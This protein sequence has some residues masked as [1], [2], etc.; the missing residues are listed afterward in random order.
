[1]KIHKKSYMRRQFCV[2]NAFF[3]KRKWAF[4]NNFFFSAVR[5]RAINTTDIGPPTHQAA[6]NVHVTKAMI[7]VNLKNLGENNDFVIILNFPV[8]ISVL[9]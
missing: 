2:Q 4:I 7:D 9:F 3:S 8:P 5:E 6:K 1:M